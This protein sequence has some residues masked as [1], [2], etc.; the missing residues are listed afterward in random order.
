MPYSGIFLLNRAFFIKIALLTIVFIQK[1]IYIENSVLG[2][3][4]CTDMG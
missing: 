2:G 1:K 3:R 4:I